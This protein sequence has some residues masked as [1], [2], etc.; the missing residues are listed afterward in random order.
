LSGS[1][2]A[3]VRYYDAFAN[4]LRLAERMRLEA[5]AHPDI[6]AA[7]GALTKETDAWR[8]GFAEPAIAAVQRGSKAD[9]SMLISAVSTDQEP[10]LSGISELSDKSPARRRS[11]TRARR[12]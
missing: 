12:L 2:A 9:I 8:T 7:L 4:E 1:S 6:E 3:A 5:A 10:T 11:S